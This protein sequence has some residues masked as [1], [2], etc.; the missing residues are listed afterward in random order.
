MGYLQKEGLRPNPETPKT[1][2]CRNS[3]YKLHTKTV[4]LPKQRIFKVG[5]K[6]SASKTCKINLYY[7][8]NNLQTML[9]ENLQM[10]ILIRK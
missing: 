4:E 3:A 6:T 5:A 7:H 8:E 1:I 10:K 2:L 9:M